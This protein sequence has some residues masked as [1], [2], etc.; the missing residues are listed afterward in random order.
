[1]AFTEILIALNATYQAMDIPSSCS[2]HSVT[3]HRLSQI[4]LPLAAHFSPALSMRKIPPLP[5]KWSIYISVQHPRKYHQLDA[6]QLLIFTG[7]SSAVNVHGEIQ[8]EVAKA[9]ESLLYSK[10]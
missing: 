3:I 2:N 9:E 10:G 7:S 8:M 6:E 4:E 5:I 1:V